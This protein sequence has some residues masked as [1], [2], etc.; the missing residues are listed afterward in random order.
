MTTCC[1][2]T[3][4]HKP[5]L[6]PNPNND[7]DT[8]RKNI[9]RALADKMSVKVTEA[10]PNAVC[11]P[12]HDDLFRTFITRYR[13][14]GGKYIACTR[15][16]LMDM[17]IRLLKSQNYF[18]LLN[19]NTQF[20]RYL[21]K[22]Q[23]NYTEALDLSDSADAAVVFSTMLVASNGSIGFIQRQS[24]YPSMK[25]IASDLIVV[26]STRYIYADVGEALRHC[27]LSKGNVAPALC[28]FLRPER[29]DGQEG[30]AAGTP[31]KPRFILLLLD[32]RV[33]ATPADGVAATPTL[34]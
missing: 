24:R 16:N 20:K 23:V 9:C 21:D 19:T 32:E 2:K 33:P 1:E 8:I 26:S 18:T 28:E 22:N 4:K 11:A 3:M 15:Q 7:K 13:L 31:Q 29:L 5:F 17:L 10:A 14:T 30:P 6:N 34:G 12:A 25:N 27:S